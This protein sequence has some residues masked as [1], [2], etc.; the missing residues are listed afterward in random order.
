[1]KKMYELLQL[2]KLLG[3]TFLNYKLQGTK[4]FIFFSLAISIICAHEKSNSKTAENYDNNKL[5]L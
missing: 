5:D 4:Y 2:W 3:E 1:M